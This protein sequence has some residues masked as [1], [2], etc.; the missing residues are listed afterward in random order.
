ML[1]DLVGVAVI[2]GVHHSRMMLLE[3]LFQ[4]GRVRVQCPSE[5]RDSHQAHDAGD[6]QQPTHR[7]QSNAERE[8]Q[9]GVGLEKRV[10]RRSRGLHRT[11]TNKKVRIE[12]AVP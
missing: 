9:V 10:N 6:E 2:E 11:P 4:V 1:I 3:L 8:D 12:N 5:A 7:R